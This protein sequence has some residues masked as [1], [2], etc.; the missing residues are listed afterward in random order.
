MDE[1]LIRPAEGMHALTVKLTAVI[2]ALA[3]IDP[4]VLRVK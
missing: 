2:E 3:A 4:T 1:A